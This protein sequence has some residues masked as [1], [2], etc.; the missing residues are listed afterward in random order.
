ML[1]Q[2]TNI[3][4]SSFAGVGGDL[5]DADKGITVSWQVNGT[6]PMTAYQIVIYN[7]DDTSNERYSSGKVELDAPFYGT[8]SMGNVTRFSVT[9]DAET[10][11]D[12]GIENDG[13]AQGFKYKITQWWSENDYIEQ[14]AENFF[15]AQTEPYITIDAD[16]VTS[17][18][19]AIT[20]NVYSQPEGVGLDW[21][22]WTITP[23]GQLV[24][25]SATQDYFGDPVFDTGILHTQIM[26]LK[27]DG[28]ISGWSYN[29][30]LYYQFQNGYQGEADGVAF[31]EWED[32]AFNGN[33]SASLAPSC[34]SAYVSYPL[35]TFATMQNAASMTATIE[36]G[37]LTIADN[38][39]VA[40][41]MTLYVDVSNGVFVWCGI[42][43]EAITFTFTDGS[44]TNTVVLDPA[45]IVTLTNGSG[46]TYTMT[47]GQDVTGRQVAFIAGYGKWYLAANTE[48]GVVVYEKDDTGA[49]NYLWWDEAHSFS[50]SGRQDCYYTGF[51]CGDSPDDTNLETILA[52]LLTVSTAQP[53]FDKDWLFLT[54]FSTDDREY[55]IGSVGA[56]EL[57]VGATVA[58]DHLAVYRT[59]SGDY[60]AKKILE[61]MSRE[62]MRELIDYG[63]V[64]GKSYT[65]RVAYYFT[66]TTSGSG[67]DPLLVAAGDEGET[68]T[69]F[70]SGTTEEITPCYWD[71][72]LATAE[73]S[74][75][76]TYRYTGQYRFGLNL[77]SG[78]ISNNNAPSLLQNFT[79]YPTRQ[80][81]SANYRSGSLTA[82]IGEVNHTE[83][84]Y[85]D[86]AAQAEAIYA[87][88]TSADAKFLRNRKGEL[89]MIDTAGATTMQL[90]DKYREQPYIATLNWVETGDTSNVSIILTPADDAWNTVF[91]REEDGGDSGGDDEGSVFSFNGTEIPRGSTITINMQ[92]FPSGSTVT[93]NGVPFEV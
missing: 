85:I 76:G 67:E 9:I 35:P 36:N 52:T 48:N 6:S 41:D 23:F 77:E 61:P 13:N 56:L 27:Y 21:V 19:Q 86:T 87:L 59:G 25:G 60:L 84:V 73:K 78:A 93:I 80:G 31:V 44:N 40:W 92:S 29:I 64:I 30:K 90:G 45:G 11:E 58:F 18:E 50:I 20:V 5:V 65:Y 62:E 42:P 91:D 17:P 75:D 24:D 53:A 14:S 51:L 32:R 74:D 37:V 10:L 34:D 22:R 15:R 71:W 83:N 57:P 47:F 33:V 46:S 26:E 4:P 70:A 16:I 72:L 43:R 8:D 49:L 28:W 12:A 89:W 88:S 54:D 3:T 66:V 68:Y 55:Y 7:N 69:V 81:V 82:Y 1:F 79:R 63:V 39:F 38:S 2:P